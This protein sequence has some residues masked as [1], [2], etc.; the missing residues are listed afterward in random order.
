[1]TLGWEVTSVDLKNA[2]INIDI[3]KWDYKTLPRNSFDLIWASPPCHTF[4]RI[5]C[6][7]IGRKLKS[8]GDTII[9]KE[10]LEQDIDNYGLPLLHK[11]FE[12]I[13]YFNPKYFVIE[14]PKSGRM[15]DYIPEELPY[16]DVD[17]CMYSNWGYQKPTRL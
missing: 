2:D 6:S 14:N 1:M 3:M 10:I 15:K 17:Y 7:W 11:T 9:T 16:Y 5:R 13:D 8:H 12:I 4:S